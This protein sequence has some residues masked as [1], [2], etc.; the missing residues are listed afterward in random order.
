MKLETPQSLDSLSPWCSFQRSRKRQQVTDIQT[1]GAFSLVRSPHVAY[2]HQSQYTTQKAGEIVFTHMVACHNEKASFEDFLEVLHCCSL[3]FV[4]YGALPFSFP[5][6]S[7][8]YIGKGP[9]NLLRWEIWR[10][11]ND[12]NECTIFQFHSLQRSWCKQI[13]YR[14]VLNFQIRV[15]KIDGLNLLSREV[16]VENSCGLLGNFTAMPT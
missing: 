3:Y 12:C 5:S 11:V 1:C 2:L 4:N 16:I 10:W 6:S 14:S 15:T 7:L 9:Y 13:F 8:L